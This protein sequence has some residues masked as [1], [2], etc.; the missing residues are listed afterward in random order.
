MRKGILYFHQGWSDIVNCLP[1]IN[2][3]SKS[4]DRLFLLIRSDSKELVDYYT[5]KMHN[6]VCVYADKQA[7]EKDFPAAIGDVLKNFVGGE[8]DFLFHGFWDRYRA[9]QYRG[10]FLRS[11]HL[12]FASSF[13]R[14]YG[15][16]ERDRVDNFVLKRDE[17][18]ERRIFNEFLAAH[19]N[20][21]VLI[22]DS[23]ERSIDVDGKRLNDSYKNPLSAIK[24]LQSAKELHII[25][26]LWA[27]ICYHIDSRYSLLKDTEITIYPFRDRAGSMFDVTREIELPRLPQNWKIQR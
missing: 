16:S 25:D 11:S 7:T 6:V 23:A 14:D 5:N 1:L 2:L 9:D 10:S 12:H 4:Y 15:F 24:I 21:R 17:E 13:Y 20:S 19:G 26:S 8:A 22:H 27:A 3:Y 18:E